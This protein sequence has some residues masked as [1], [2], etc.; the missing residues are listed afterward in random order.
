MLTKQLL[1]SN[2]FLIYCYLLC[3]VI[4][5]TEMFARIAKSETTL[6]NQKRQTRD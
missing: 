4:V 5:P 6:F 1:T 3:T 2:L